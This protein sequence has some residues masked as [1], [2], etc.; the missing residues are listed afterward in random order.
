MAFCTKCGGKLKEGADFCTKCG[1]KLGV[2]VPAAERIVAPAA[3]VAPAAEAPPAKDNR[4]AVLGTW[5]YIGV[6]ILFSIP[7][8]GFIFS[9]I[10][11][12]SGSV[13]LN[14]RNV[15]RAYLILLAIG[16]GFA[17]VFFSLILFVGAA[18]FAALDWTSLSDWLEKLNELSLE[19]NIN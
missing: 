18:F 9:I 14:L 3:P 7:V 4:N 8:I 15:S 17:M 19:V 2:E 13:N 6:T 1:N 12:C 11:A 16:V 10:W 5:A